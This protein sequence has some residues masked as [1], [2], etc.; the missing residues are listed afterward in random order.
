MTNKTKK[1]IEPERLPLILRKKQ[2]LAMVNLSASTVYSMQK[3]G[4]FPG[5]V[6]LLIGVHLKLVE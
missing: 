1:A 2:V 4:A 6:G 5:C 3:A